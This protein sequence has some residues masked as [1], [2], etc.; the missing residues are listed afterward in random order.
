MKFDMTDL[1]KKHGVDLGKFEPTLIDGIKTMGDGKLYFL[2]VTNLVQIMFYNKGIFDKFGVPYPKDGMTWDEVGELN[3]KMTRSEGGLSYL[4][5]S[6]SPAHILNMSQYSMPL[7]DP[8]TKKPM[9]TDERWKAA[10]ERYFLNEASSSYKTWS[11]EKK[12]LPYYTEMTASQELATMVFNSQFP[13]DGP[14]YVKDIDWDLVALPT[15]KDKPKLGSQASP[16]MFAITGTAKNKGPAMEV[17]KQLTSVEVQ[18]EISKQGFMTV[19]NDDNVKKLIG[20]ESQ[21]K[22]KNWKAVYYNEIAPKAY[23]S[24]YDGDILQKF[25]SPVVLKVVT[26]Q[27]DLNTALREAQDQAEKFVQAEQQ[28]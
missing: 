2:P 12:K 18:T 10:I 24:I 14:Q 11:T 22:N 1:V 4:G 26:G 19:L 8:K 7:Y 27:T 6:A 15:T 25:L 9:L 17:I 5:Y 13:F 28:K 21:F 23:Q 20:S 16:R 3:R